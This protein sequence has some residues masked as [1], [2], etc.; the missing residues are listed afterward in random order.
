MY[1]LQK[2]DVGKSVGSWHGILGGGLGEK[3]QSWL[4]MGAHSRFFGLGGIELGVGDGIV[5]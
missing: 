4:G 1:G 5:D 2:R 3:D